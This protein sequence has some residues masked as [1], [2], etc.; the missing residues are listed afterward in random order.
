MLGAISAAISATT[1]MTTSASSSVTPASRSPAAD[2]LCLAGAARLLVRA[3]RKD[4]DFA[5]LPWNFVEIRRPPGIH[6]RALLLQVRAIPA[7]GALRR[8][9]EP[10]QP[11]LGR[12]VTPDIQPEQLERRHHI[13]DLY[14][15]GLRARGAEI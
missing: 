8:I 7:V 15:R 11:F 13:V 14:F 5:V 2:I 10:L 6:E 9:D 3:E 4:I 12:G 1:A